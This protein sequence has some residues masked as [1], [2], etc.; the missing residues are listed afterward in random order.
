[1]SSSQEE[2]S[3]GGGC[4]VRNSKNRAHIQISNILCVLILRILKAPKNPGI[5]SPKAETTRLCDY[6]IHLPFW[7][8]FSTTQD[9]YKKGTPNF[10]RPNTTILIYPCLPLHCAFSYSKGTPKCTL[11]SNTLNPKPCNRSRP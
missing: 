2:P 9:N 8:I 3:D 1:M 4:I 6:T 7:V 10:W 5:P 11:P